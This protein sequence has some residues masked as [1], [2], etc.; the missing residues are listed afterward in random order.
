MKC[1]E[2][3]ITIVGGGCIG[4][5]ILYE[6]TRRGFANVALIDHGRKTVSATASSGGMLRVFHESAEHVELALAN[7]SLLQTH[8]RAGILSE[9]PEADGSLYFFN[10]HRYQD[11]QPNLKRM[12]KAAYPF[13]VLTS[14][15]GRKRFPQFKWNKDEWAIYEPQGS[16]LSPQLFVEDLISSSVRGGAVLIDDFQVQRLSRYRSQHRISGND[17]TVTT[18]TLI[19]AGGARLLPRLRDLGLNLALEA[20]T[21]TSFVVQKT[22]NDLIL[23]NYFDRESLEFGRL[24]HGSHVVLSDPACPRIVDRLWRGT[25]EKRL[26]EDCYAP[27]RL[28]FSGQVSGLP[29]LNLATGWGG[30][31]F[32]FA[33]AIG[34]RIAASLELNRYFGRE[35]VG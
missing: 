5:S 25:I 32:K 19:L 35:A 23:P 29:R 14:S 16:H 20:R 8:H 11:Y 22:Q 34:N 26:A 28:G 33:L 9:K 6:L 1:F 24:G 10:K 2:F 21:L 7:H 4:S 31:G 27:N 30:T 3:D 15:C 13:E 12:D 18:K 17:A